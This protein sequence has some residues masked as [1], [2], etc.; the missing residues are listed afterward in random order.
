MPEDDA[1]RHGVGKGFEE[2]CRSE[3]I[4]IPAAR[5]AGFNLLRRALRTF[6]K[7]SVPPE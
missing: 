5:T 7:T 2:L 4:R 6:E 3:N 1:D